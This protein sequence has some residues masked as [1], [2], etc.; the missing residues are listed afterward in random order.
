MLTNSQIDVLER[1]VCRLLGDVGM[2]FENAEVR[3]LLVKKG[4]TE[5]P[6]GRTRIPRELIRELTDYQKRTQAED[7]DDQGLMHLCG[8]GVAWAHFIIYKGQKE[9]ARKEAGERFRMSIFGS[10]ANKI[11]DSAT[12]AAESVTTDGYIRMLK[13]VSATPEF[14]YIAPFYRVDG[15]PRLE[16]LEALVLGL[17]Y[18]PDEVAGV[19]PMYPEEIK[20]IREIGEVMGVS[21]DNVPYLSGSIAVNR[22]LVVDSRNLDQLLERRKRGIRRYRVANMPTF[23]LSTPAT[24][25][26]AIVLSAADIIGGMVAVLCVERE[27]EVTGRT[28]AN[29]ID[30]RNAICTSCAPEP[31][32]HNIGVKELFDARFGG[33]LWTEPFFAVS[34]KIPGLQAVYENFFGAD[35]YARLTGIPTLYPGL[36]TVGYMGAASPTQAMLDMHIRGS[37][38]ALSDSIVVDEE[39]LAYSEISEVLASGT[40]IFMDRE[41]AAAH[42]GELW[43]SELF[44]N[45]FPSP[46]WPG[47]E[48]CLLARCD[49][50]WR[51]NVA[52]YAPPDVPVHRAKALEDILQR[53]KRELAS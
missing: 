4:C 52:R 18:A 31:T 23:G 5:T 36:G 49:E 7:A 53:A 9:R 19:E 20:Y 17:Q 2:S 22:P 50:M 10:G 47:D 8:P 44:L 14:G 25:A 48:K 32:L 35:R 38:A 37:Q 30:K 42:F 24:M 41:H 6:E 12:G 15:H 33:H 11:Y 26:A 16:R 1:D 40:D 29:S 45:E 13:L 51:E 34:A 28:I 21:A 3:A 46:S 27:A 39:T 43:A